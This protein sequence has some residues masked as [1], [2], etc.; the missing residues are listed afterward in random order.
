MDATENRYIEISSEFT[1]EIL[2]EYRLSPEEDMIE[3]YKRALLVLSD[4]KSTKFDL[5]LKAHV[6]S[7]F[8]GMSKKQRIKIFE[9][10]QWITKILNLER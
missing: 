4:V 10:S 9:K 3:V 8:G 5:L 6:V 7:K 2:K 1:H